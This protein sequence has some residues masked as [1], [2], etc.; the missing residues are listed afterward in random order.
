MLRGISSFLPMI[1]IE[2]REIP[3]TWR[4]GDLRVIFCDCISQWRGVGERAQGVL[5][6]GLRGE[7]YEEWHK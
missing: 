6:L 3:V 7:D 4:Q 2:T 1:E 5:D